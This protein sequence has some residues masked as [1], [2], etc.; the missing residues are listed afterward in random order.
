[1]FSPFFLLLLLIPFH[2][3]G[4]E[5]L[6]SFNGVI[7]HR[8]VGCLLLTL[9]CQQ[10]IIS[11]FGSSVSHSI[12]VLLLHETVRPRSLLQLLVF[13]SFDEVVD[14]SF[15]EQIRFRLL[16]RS[17]LAICGTLVHPVYPI[18]TLFASRSLELPLEVF[19][20][21]F[22]LDLID[23]LLRA[24]ALGEGFL[25]FIVDH[26]LVASQSRMK[27]LFQVQITATHGCETVLLRYLVVEVEE[28]GFGGV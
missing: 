3:H 4:C 23:T 20:G 16:C 26:G 5:K 6:P 21:S 2:T 27:G 14:S 12:G 18:N 19:L 24:L 22:F 25:L 17:G 13:R 8:I 9:D 7:H 15:P 28:N 11:D 1:M 10:R